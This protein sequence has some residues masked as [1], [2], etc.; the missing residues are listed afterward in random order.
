MGLDSHKLP[1]ATLSAN[2]YMTLLYVCF[3]ANT[4]HLTYTVDSLTLNSRLRALEWCQKAAH[5]ARL[6]QEA[7]HNFLGMRTF[8]STSA[9]GLGAF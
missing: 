8:D 1:V 2:Q 4:P 7:Q 5:L 6:L 9:P 3:C